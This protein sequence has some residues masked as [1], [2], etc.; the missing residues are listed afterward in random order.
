MGKGARYGGYG[1][2]GKGSRRQGKGGEGGKGR[3]KGGG[4]PQFWKKFL[5]EG[6][7]LKYSDGGGGGR[8]QR[9]AESPTAKRMRL[10]KIQNQ[11]RERE[12][13]LLHSVGL[14]V[15]QLNGRLRLLIC[16]SQT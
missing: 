16:L 8:S 7:P 12:V 9:E 1:K 15:P 5:P 14:E 2:G 3:G 4:G 10:E 11:K 13:Q 6:H